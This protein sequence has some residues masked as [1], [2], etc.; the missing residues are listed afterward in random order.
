[1]V[2]GQRVD[3]SR[4]RANLLTVIAEGVSEVVVGESGVLVIAITPAGAARHGF[5][6]CL[7]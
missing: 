6:S 2:R 7:E 4:I 5:R 1:M 3:L